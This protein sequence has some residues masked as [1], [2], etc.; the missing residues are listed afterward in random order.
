MKTISHRSTDTPRPVPPNTDEPGL[1]E[2]ALRTRQQGGDQALEALLARHRDW[3][4]RRCLTW[5]R[6]RADAE[7]VAQ[8]VLL[9]V[10]S[11]LKGLEQHTRFRAWLARIV[12]NQCKTHL[13]R[14]RWITVEHIERLIDLRDMELGAD[15][16]SIEDLEGARRQVRLAL[17]QL[18][19]ES[20]HVLYL[21]FFQDL[22][23]EQIARRL[24]LS[25]SAAKMRLY[26]AQDRFAAGYQ[27]LEN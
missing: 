17:D 5:T 2:L 12:D 13:A 18:P 4:V 24:D 14:R 1:I 25:L 10:C 21:R 23:L 11:G 7:D 26:R 22:S 15:A 27:G 20:A 19:T 16:D 3:V 8:E 6:S 9:R